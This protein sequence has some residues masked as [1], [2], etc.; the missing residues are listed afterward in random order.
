VNREPLNPR[1]IPIPP[2]FREH[3][4]V[5]CPV[6]DPNNAKQTYAAL[7]AD[8][9]PSTKLENVLLPLPLNSFHM[10]QAKLGMITARKGLRALPPSHFAWVGR[11]VP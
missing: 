2:P 5:V 9:Q 1:T 6:F 11:S 4:V 3:L 8:L 7:N 10:N